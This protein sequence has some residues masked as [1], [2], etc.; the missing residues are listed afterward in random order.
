MAQRV[1]LA[2]FFGWTELL[3]LVIPIIKGKLLR[4]TLERLGRKPHW[5]E[6]NNFI[7]ER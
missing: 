4:E 2:G 6:G 7:T 5:F 1:S 3:K